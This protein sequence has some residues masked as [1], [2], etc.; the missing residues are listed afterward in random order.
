[1]NKEAAKFWA[2]DKQHQQA[3][4]DA[5]F[6]NSLPGVENSKF[7]AFDKLLNSGSAHEIEALLEE[8]YNVSLIKE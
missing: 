3:I 2:K 6:K 1:M 7:I 8:E 4:V 5:I